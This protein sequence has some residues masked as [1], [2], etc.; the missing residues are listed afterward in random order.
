M[1]VAATQQMTDLRQRNDVL[2][3][4]HRL[5]LV[6][7]HALETV[8][9]SNQSTV[10]NSSRLSESKLVLTLLSVLVTFLGRLR[11]YPNARIQTGPNP[12]L[13]L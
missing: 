8:R 11:S 5:H 10:R 4:I 13:A 9:K 7:G 2:L 1:T 12:N 3:Q 6:V